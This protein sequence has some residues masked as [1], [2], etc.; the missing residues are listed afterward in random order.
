[1][2]SFSLNQSLNAGPQWIGS[3]PIAN[4]QILSSIDAGQTRY[5]RTLTSRCVLISKSLLPVVRHLPDTM[6][7]LSYNSTSSFSNIDFLMS[8]HIVVKTDSTKRYDI[9]SGFCARTT[10]HLFGMC[11]VS[12]HMGLTK[13]RRR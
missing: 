5:C 7:F 2:K 4:V 1:M 11:V 10:A 13:Q 8:A 9:R 3:V 12:T 6:C